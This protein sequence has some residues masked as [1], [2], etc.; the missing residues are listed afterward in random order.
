M[1]GLEVCATD[2]RTQ[3]GLRLRLILGLIAL[4]YSQ[5][6]RAFSLILTLGML[7]LNAILSAVGWWR[8]DLLAWSADNYFQPDG[9]SSV[10]HSLCPLTPIAIARH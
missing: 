10:S 1:L 9:I 7:G 5:H 2:T 8:G 3:P 4:M 6:S